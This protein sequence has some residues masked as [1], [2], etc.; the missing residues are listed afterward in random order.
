MADFL[1]HSE[2]IDRAAGVYNMAASLLNSF[3]SVIFLMVLTRVAGTE[4]AGMFTIAFA[5][6]NMFLTVAKYGMRHYQASDRHEEFSFRQ[7]VISRALS[8]IGM[9][10]IGAVCIGATAAANGYSDRKCGIML[11]MLLLRLPDAIEDVWYGRYQ[12][13]GRLDVA[14]KAMTVRMV[15]EIAVYLLLT[16]TTKDQYKAVVG[17]SVLNLAALVYVLHATSDVFG[18]AE[19]GREEENRNGKNDRSGR[20]NRDNRDNRNDRNDRS[21]EDIA[22]ALRLLR[23]CCPL[24]LGSFLT[25]YVTNAPKYAIDA[26]LSDEE[27]AYY[28]YLSMPVSMIGLLGGFLFIPMLYE[29]TRLWD[30]GALGVFRKRC[31]RIAGM[32]AGI[33]GVCLAAAFVAGI[34]VLSLLFHADLSAHRGDLLILLTG[35]G[36]S[37]LAAFLNAIVTVMR[38]QKEL[39]FGYAATAVLAALV[40]NETV[41]LAG[42]RGASL[43]FAGLMA[44]Q[45]GCFAAVMVR[46]MRRRAALIGGD[47]A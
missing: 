4:E 34:P 37:A 15:W 42:M 29:F 32:V 30:E 19:A 2:N 3:Q 44:V 45:C 8:C 6:S 39:L 1:T 18:P 9:L 33:T 41:R 47:N 46:G 11:W 40:S 20:N 16:V 27:Q 43:L 23:N 5:Y 36:F 28:G 17:T 13:R 7:Y 35:G 38:R 24:F 12:Q 14:A 10:V 21:R 25:I 22:G 26:I 31:V